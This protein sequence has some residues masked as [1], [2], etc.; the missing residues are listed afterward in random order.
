MHFRFVFITSLLLSFLSRVAWSQSI[1]RVEPANWWT[2]MRHSS[3]QLLVY[4]DNISK[5]SPS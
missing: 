2:G 3:I 5:L 1:S 4:G